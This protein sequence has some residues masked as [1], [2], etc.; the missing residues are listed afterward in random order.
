MRCGRFQV[1][2]I[3][4]TVTGFDSRRRYQRISF[5]GRTG[6]FQ[7][8]DVSSILTFRSSFRGR[9]LEARIGPCHGP[10]T[11]SN[12]VTRSN[13]CDCSTAGI[14]QEAG[15]LTRNEDMVRLRVSLPAPFS[16]AWPRR[17]R[18]TP[19]M[20]EIVSSILTAS[21]MPM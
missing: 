18:H 11:G 3:T 5:S 6:V 12:P 1:A 8:P 20:G 17:V 2:L 15:R 10:D 4:L 16:L 13:C 7:T 19:G 14:A 9:R 21:S